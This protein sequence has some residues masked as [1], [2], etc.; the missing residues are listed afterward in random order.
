MKT[1]DGEEENGSVGRRKRSRVNQLVM[2]RKPIQM[3]TQ[4]RQEDEQVQDEVERDRNNKN[5]NK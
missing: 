5:K 3:K 4:R 1:V 2:E